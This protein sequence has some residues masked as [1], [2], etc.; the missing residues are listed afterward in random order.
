MQSIKA[1]SARSS[2]SALQRI[3]LGAEAAE[4]EFRTLEDYF[5]E[6]A[7]FL[8]TARGEVRI[9]AGR[10]GSGKTAIFFMVRDSFRR[11]RNTVI[12]DLR[13]SPT[14]SACSKASYRKSSTSAPSTTRSRRSGT[15]WSSR[16]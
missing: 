6:T 10:K 9:V 14:N 4:N 13:R 3:T 1:P 12:S 15:S 16:K 2:K 8:K 5:V 11:Q 7:E